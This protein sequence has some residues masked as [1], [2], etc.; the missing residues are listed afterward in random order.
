MSWAKVV[1]WPW[2]WLCEPVSTSTEPVGIDAHLGRF[3]Q[4]DAGTQRANGRARRDAA[5]LDVGREAQPALLAVL[6]ACRLAR[7]EALVVG[8]LQR[9]VEAGRV[10]AR[11]VG[12]DDGRGVREALDEVLAAELGR[13]LA[14]SRAP[15]PR[16]GAPPRRSPRAGR[17]RD[18]HR[19]A[20]CWCRRRRPRNR[21]RGCRTGPTAAA[22]RDR[23]A[24]RRRRS[25]GSRRGWPWSWPERQDLAVGVERQ[26]GRRHVVAAVRVGEERFACARPTH[27]TGRPTFLRAPTG[28][29]SPPRR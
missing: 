24:R 23:S 1:S 20:P 26:L 5:G 2:P 29:P 17:R 10:V 19:P 16:P 18:R 28:T 12:H 7:A 14:R 9:L 3:P 11:V 4:A 22:R 15:P 25:R 8:Q 27:F 13:V 21:W 6:G